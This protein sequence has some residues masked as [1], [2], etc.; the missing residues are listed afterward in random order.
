MTAHETFRT[1]RRHA[2]VLSII[3]LAM[4]AGGMAAA[5]QSLTLE[6]DLI[7]LTFTPDGATKSLLEK[8]TIHEWLATEQHPCAGCRSRRTD[9]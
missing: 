7:R 5:G 8:S 1:T 3:C 4:S 9:R 2:G 6:N